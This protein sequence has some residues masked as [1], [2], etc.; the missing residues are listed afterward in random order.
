MKKLSFVVFLLL[1]FSSSVNAV[2]WPQP[3]S[4]PPPADG[5][6]YRGET[7]W[8]NTYADYV[9][10][11]S[12]W[13]LVSC[14]LP[15]AD[16]LPGRNDGPTFGLDDLVKTSMEGMFDS[17]CGGYCI[18]GFCINTRLKI[19]WRGIKFYTIV[20]PKLRTTTPDL[21][22]AS[23]NHTGDHPFDAWQNT[24][25]QVLKAG[26]TSIISRLLGAEDG[27]QGGRGAPDQLDRHQS[28]SFKE[29]SIIGHPAN[30]LPEVVKVDGDI[31]DLPPANYQIPRL[32]SLPSQ[33]VADQI[34]SNN[35]NAARDPNQP[36]ASD[37]DLSEMFDNT[38]VRVKDEIRG[39]LE[40]AIRTLS[41]VELLQSIE[42]EIGAI[43]DVAELVETGLTTIETAFRSSVYANAANP[44]FVIDRLFCPTNMQPL[45][46]HY[47]SLADAFYWRTGYP[48][49][50]GPIS[51]SDKSTTILNPLSDDTL[52]PNSLETWGHMYPREG[53]VNSNHDAKVGTVT[54]WRGLDVL[55]NNIK[56]GANGTRVGVPL[57]GNY[58]RN[59][60]WQMIYPEVKA[61]QVTPAYDNNDATLDFMEPNAEYSSYAWNYYNTQECCSHPMKGNILS[62][63]IDF[64][65]PICF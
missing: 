49:T 48:I 17:S 10:L 6:V 33:N 16:G 26:N 9:D 60:R 42:R 35:N 21:L 23:Y 58:P 31:D 18:T 59:G 51:G 7:C 3:P 38:L 44:R 40:A 61:C 2:C 13:V 45:Q 30:I 20:S 1:S 12:R 53:A 36:Q 46:P 57:P 29:V 54:A 47:L 65:S 52:K 32:G 62:T 8:V 50:D 19:S 64:P 27:L 24:F 28:L 56:D 4:Y 37:F 15:R 34:D 63:S 22:I 25:E 43:Q 14:P 11:V 55:L 5:C 41:G 39:K